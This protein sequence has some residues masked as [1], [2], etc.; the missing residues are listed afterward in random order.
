MSIVGGSKMSLSKHINVSSAEEARLRLAAIVE[1]SDDAIV[2]KTLD[3]II[4]SWNAAATRLFG[5]LPDEI[6]GRSILTIIP[7]ELHPEEAVILSKLRAGERIDH[8]E[9]RRLRKDGTLVEVSLTISP[10]KDS[11]GRVIGSSKIARDISERNRTQAA[12]IQSEKLAAVGRMAAAI[13]HEVNNPLEAITNL[14]YL[15]VR[16][17]SL[18][19]EARGWAR[20]LLDEVGRASRITKQTLAYYRETDRATAVNIPDL[21]DSVIDLHHPALT[22]KNI[23]VH[24][25]YVSDSATVQG[26][27]S[28]LRQVIANLIL[29]ATDA[30]DIG[31]Q[32]WIKI[33]NYRDGMLRISIADSGSGISKERRQHLFRPFYTTKGG[34]GTGLGLWVS[35]GIIRKHGGKIRVRSS[36]TPGHRGTIFTVLLPA[37]QPHSEV[38]RAA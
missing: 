13:A 29:N 15:L 20:L 30:M 8:F 16:Q 26:F 4:T 37:H 10:M 33:A 5:Y 7:P 32:L 23:G 28:E 36:T 19:E 18:D 3:G 27:A 24:R 38:L 1:S 34:S 9:T 21:I 22:K 6:I 12:L 25:Q 17:P 14:A 35:D 11:T 31:G 2:S